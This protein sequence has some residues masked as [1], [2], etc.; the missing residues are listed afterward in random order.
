VLENPAYNVEK[1]LDNRT[2]ELVALPE[3]ELEALANKARG[4]IDAREDAA[5]QTI[6]R[7]HKVI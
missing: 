3:S 5:L 7:A 6:A 4:E 2:K 1:Y